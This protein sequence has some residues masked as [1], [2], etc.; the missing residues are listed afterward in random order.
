M[1][2]RRYD[3]AFAR[4]TRMPKLPKSGLVQILANVGVIASIVF[5]AMEVRDN[6]TQA[7]TS[8]TLEVSSQI[9]EWRYKISDDPEI[10]DIYRTG[11]SNYGDLSATDRVRFDALMRSLLLLTSSAIR[12]R[13]VGLLPLTTDL[14][15]RALEANLV[16]HLEQPGFREWWK[17][18]DKRGI[19]VFIAAF[20]ASSVEPTELD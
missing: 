17:T 11:L 9:N 10:A 6:A 1:A 12:A 7:R 4:G 3:L 15:E 8:A 14:Q 16:R 19:P 13:D 20:V 2:V 18:A 5:L